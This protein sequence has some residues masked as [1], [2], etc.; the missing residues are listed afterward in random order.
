MR[1]AAAAGGE[2]DFPETQWSLILRAR[3]ER[4]TTRREALQALCQRYWKPVY[5]YCR[6]AWSKSPEDAEDLAQAFFLMLIDRDALDRYD[7]GRGH[8]RPYLKTLLRNFERDRHDHVTAYKRGGGRKPVSMDAGERKRLEATLADPRAPDPE[9][10][11]D[12][13][14]KRE[15]LG[16]A[17]ER[18]REAF[19]SSGRGLKIR[20]FEAHDLAPGDG[21][22]SY[23]EL[24]S[25]F[26]VKTS[27]IRNALFE[28]REQIRAEACRDIA[29]TVPDRTEV[30]TEYRDLFGT[31][32]EKRAN[33]RPPFPNR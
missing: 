25:R 11:F 27:G 2:R 5:G 9:R 28:V 7:P 8:F 12:L 32:S 4:T 14:W 31:S 17:V 15:V 18:V 20:I 29:Q 26:G 13:A 1:E 33:D 3:G 19:E 21:P 23:E 24:A 22:P 10:T 30:D 6:R 16:R